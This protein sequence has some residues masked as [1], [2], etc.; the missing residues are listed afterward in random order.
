M[1]GLKST[2]LVERELNM[3]ERILLITQLRVMMDELIR[4]LRNGKSS[5]HPVIRAIA[6]ESWV[7]IARNLESFPDE[8]LSLITL[9]LKTAMTNAWNAIGREIA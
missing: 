1:H 6:I 4:D 8:R 7:L 3:S 5:I 9:D 2:N